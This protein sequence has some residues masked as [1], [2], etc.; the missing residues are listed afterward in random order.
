M[1]VTGF[2]PERDDASQPVLDR[3]A[4]RL[5]F[6]FRNVF[7]RKLPN[8]AAFAA[9]VER[10][11][12]RA[13]GAALA[14][15]VP[16]LRY[17]LRRDGFRSELIAECLG[18]YCAA[19]PEAVAP[20]ALAA[21][22]WLVQGGLAE[23]ADPGDSRH[24]L[25]A[26]ALARAIR[27]DCVH[28]LTASDAAA[29]SL[30]Q[31]IQHPFLALGLRVGSIARG[32]N[33]AARREA[34]SCDI[35]C[36]A[37]REVAYDYL[38]DGIRARGRPG[39]VRSRLE[40][41][42]TP[43]DA[44]FLLRG[45]QCALVENADLA[46][47]DDAPAPLIIATDADQSRERLMYEQA[48]ELARALVPE[49]DFTV[50]EQGIR[51]AD[52]AARLLERLVAPLGGIWAAR[53]R[54]E[55]LIAAALE[56]LHFLQR[57]ADYRVEQGRVVF[58]QPAGAP[59]EPSAEAQEITKLVEVKEGC[60][61]GAR[62]EVLARMFLPRFF[63]RYLHL[64]GVCADARG[65]EADF[66]TLYALKTRLAG[67]RAAAVTPRVR[68]FLTNEAK[69]AALA[70]RAE[71]PLSL[72]INELP[73]SSRHIER[74]CAAHGVRF[75][76]LLI[77][78]E[79]EAVTEHI[80]PALASAAR[81]MAGAHGELAPWLARWLAGRAQRK[82]ER[83]SRALRLELKARDE[84]LDSLLAFSGQRE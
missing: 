81:L 65:L 18:L 63:A 34:Y 45:L 10:F 26:A 35:V 36:G 70:A 51:L 31:S 9:D 73:D 82:A 40:R 4:A 20:Q 59:E 47:L 83:A 74:M 76:E 49:K 52:P 25:A 28:L 22:R 41:L 71:N 13:R 37:C 78:L 62:R 32:T 46:M 12:A 72:L 61:L 66:W 53:Q 69:R 5:G 84:T 21:A 48:L 30:A 75:C 33:A 7:A 15:L 57:D 68:V 11:A 1:T 79:D 17:R 43:G 58:P 16:A 80:G 24:A 27:G 44:A 8:R 42:S 14:P 50:D 19:T 38:R 67:A 2:Y 64:A 23:L 77:S 56:A 6:A 60:R 54:R 3:A 39:A 29:S 55:A